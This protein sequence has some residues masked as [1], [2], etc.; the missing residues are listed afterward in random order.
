M[1]IPSVSHWIF[2]VSIKEGRC[3][4]K[5][6]NWQIHISNHLIIIRSYA[7]DMMS[8]LYNSAM[9]STRC[10]LVINKNHTVDHLLMFVVAVP[11]YNACTHNQPQI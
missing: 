4:C 6:L 1:I 2:V 11:V 3:N 7:L 10:W 5:R 9:N 8:I